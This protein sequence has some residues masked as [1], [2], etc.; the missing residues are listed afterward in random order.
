MYHLVQIEN[1]SLEQQVENVMLDALVHYI[2]ARC[3]NPAKLGATKLN[4]VL[5]YSDVF[6]FAETGASITG[7]TYIK[8]QFGPVPKDII[9]SRIRLQNSGAI[10]ER[11]A[12]VYDYNQVQFVAVKKPD[13]SKFSAT[14]ISLVDGVITAICAN[15]T[16]ASISNLSHDY[17]WESAQIGEEIP[18]AA[19]AFGGN[20]GEINEDDIA[21]AR[22]E[23][24]R[25]ERIESS[26]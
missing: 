21:W 4:K 26:P 19:A 25:I 8:R 22:N 17:I 15:H 18:M 1:I 24:D 7:A 10:V 23:I 6:A 13:I 11:H 9:A 3:E 12:S 20:F 16:A 14:Q 5:W 2:C